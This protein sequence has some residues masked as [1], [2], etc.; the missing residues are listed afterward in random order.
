MDN[1]EDF[2]NQPVTVADD[3]RRYKGVLNKKKCKV[4]FGMAKDM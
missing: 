3:V 2:V 1:L 4:D